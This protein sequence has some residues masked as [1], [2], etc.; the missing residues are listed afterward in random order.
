[1]SGSI[2][3]IIGS[4]S[5]LLLV[6]L[7]LLLL[8]APQAETFVYG[9]AL[10]NLLFALVLLAAIHSVSGLNWH[11]SLAISLAAVWLALQLWGNATQSQPLEMAAMIVLI[12]FG[13]H[14]SAVLLWRA[15]TAERVDFEVVCAL[16]SIYLLLAITWA[17][18]YQVIETLSP[19]SFQGGR[20][21]ALLGIVEFLYFSLTT[22]TT[23]GY[24]D[25]TPVGPTTRMWVTLEAVAGVFY[26]AVLVARLVTL[27]RS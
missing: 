11:R 15:V 6:S 12:C 4:R 13:S 24:G 1:M 22:I 27:Y 23:L 25:I 17:V 21:G 10:T 19:G 18:S 16:P 9:R 8:T 26:I 14:T 20:D 7:A 2:R 5:L 3:I